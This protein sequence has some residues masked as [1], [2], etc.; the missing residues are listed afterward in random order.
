MTFCS[1]RRILYE[2]ATNAGRR[3]WYHV[4]LQTGVGVPTVPS[5]DE[6]VC[7]F[8]GTINGKPFLTA[9]LTGCI[10]G[11]FKVENCKENVVESINTISLFCVPKSVIKFRL[12]PRS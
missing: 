12:F 1:L 2:F 7:K 5:S 8:R 6:D 3:E 9:P 4:K 10:E 11:F